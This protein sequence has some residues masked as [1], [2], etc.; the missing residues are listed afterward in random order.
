MDLH[1]THEQYL[2][3][4]DIRDEATRTI[5]GGVDDAVLNR[6]IVSLFGTDIARQIISESLSGRAVNI[7]VAELA[8][9]RAGRAGE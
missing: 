4:L 3:L 2:R 6:G 5:D 7:I 8:A 9:L 1:I